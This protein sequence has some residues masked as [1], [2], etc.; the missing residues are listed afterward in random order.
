M[1][2]KLIAV[3]TILAITASMHNT[4]LTMKT[5][6]MITRRTCPISPHFPILAPIFEGW[7]L[8]VATNEEK[9]DGKVLITFV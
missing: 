2:L 6:L 3:A 4:G 1:Y 5:Q 7:I 8:N 9:S